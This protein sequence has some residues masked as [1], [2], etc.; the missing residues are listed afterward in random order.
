MKHILYKFIA[1]SFIIA[2]AVSCVD[3][4]QEPNSFLTEEEYIEYPKDVESVTR[5]IS[6]LYNQLRGTNDKGLHDNYG[7]N[8]RLQRLNISADDITYSPTK[9]NNPLGT[10]E[11]LT[12]SITGNDPDF[13]TT[14]TL[15]FKVINN[16]N[17]IIEGT[18]ITDNEKEKLQE[19]IAEAYFLRGL[20]YFYL[21]RLYG[22]L[23]L[24]LT[25]DD[26]Q[27]TMQRSSVSDIYDKA[28]IPSLKK[29]AEWLPSTSR[30][31]DNSTPSKWAAKACLAEAYMT[32]AGWPL[33]KGKEYYSLATTELESIIDES[34]LDLENEYKDLW[35]EDL[36]TSTKE[37]MF[38]IHHSVK[39]K[40]AS[41]YGKS[42][43]PADFYPK[44]GWADYYANE[45]FYLKYPNDKRKAWNYM[46]EW[47]IAENQTINYKKSKDGLPAISKYYDY[48]EGVPGNSQLSNGIT[49]IYRFADVL[50]MYAEASTR[51]TQTVNA[52]AIN[53]INRV[54]KRAGYIENNINL[55]N[56]TNPEEFLQDVFNE[57]GW[58]FFAEMK[59]WFDLV[60]LEKVSEVK[61][62]EWAGSTFKNN[63]HYYFPI[64]YQQINLT[65]W[66]NNPG[67]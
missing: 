42:Y 39:S 57:R 64:P 35:K 5:S 10:L 4:N 31:G 65:G 8:C 60:R 50:L 67:Y 3:L 40:T 38:S 46:T 54:Q 59:R 45:S 32:M 16:S 41:N 36:K 29:A 30:S 23:P 51:A 28:I 53:S 61:P 55:T 11:S 2:N 62:T 43:Y 12:P 49:C 15:F 1:G 52:K 58:E 17:K 13:Q 48:N 19:V 56:T 9:A 21:V 44:A 25:K 33:N 63:N 6:G 20:S 34:G 24:V 14:W 18:P 66:T 7:F 22:D 26:L 27:L 47:K 37:H